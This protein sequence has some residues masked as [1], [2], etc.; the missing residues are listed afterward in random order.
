MNWGEQVGGGGVDRLGVFKIGGEMGLGS[1][2]GPVL[3]SGG[4]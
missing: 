1:R 2:R 4:R 3:R